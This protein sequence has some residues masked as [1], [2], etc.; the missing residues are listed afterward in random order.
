MTCIL[1]LNV[2]QYVQG[3]SIGRTPGFENAAGKLKQKWYVS[4]KRN[5]IHQNWDPHFT[6]ALYITPMEMIKVIQG[7]P[8]SRALYIP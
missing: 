6:G 8:F 5:K 4:K 1:E 3:A 2:L 7:P